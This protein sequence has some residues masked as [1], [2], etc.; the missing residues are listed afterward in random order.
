M[1]SNTC[2]HAEHGRS[3]LLRHG[4]FDGRDMDCLVSLNETLGAT[5]IGRVRGRRPSGHRLVQQRELQYQARAWA[6]QYRSVLTV[7]EQAAYA[8][9]YGP[10]TTF[11][12]S[13]SRCV[14]GTAA[15]AISERSSTPDT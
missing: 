5:D 10:P 4:G 8:E 11:E 15:A 6:R 12:N 14:A 2:Y 7:A 9:K 13:A 1:R 3:R